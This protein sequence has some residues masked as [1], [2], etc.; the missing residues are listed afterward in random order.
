MVKMPTL[1]GISKF[2]SRINDWLWWFKPENSIDFSHFNI[3]EHFKFYA[4]LRGATSQLICTLMFAFAKRRFSNDSAQL[5][6]S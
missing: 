3:Y 5:C 1:V 4:Q 6:L 2:I